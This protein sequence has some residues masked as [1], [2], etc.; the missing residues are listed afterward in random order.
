M[1]VLRL[2]KRVLAW[3]DPS[4]MAITT[5]L[6]ANMATATSVQELAFA[7]LGM[8]VL[9]AHSVTART[10]YWDPCV[11]PKSSAQVTAAVL[12]HATSSTE[13]ARAFRID[14]AQLAK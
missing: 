5:A 2:D 14:K 13:P 8:W 3:W 12:V 6:L 10:S 1:K 4:Q 11:Y 9:I 7:T